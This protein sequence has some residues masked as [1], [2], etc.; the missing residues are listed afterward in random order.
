MKNIVYRVDGHH[1]AASQCTNQRMGREIEQ[2]DEVLYRRQKLSDRRGA[3]G[4]Q[5]WQQRADYVIA[6]EVATTNANPY[7]HRN[8]NLLQQ[9][10]DQLRFLWLQLDQIYCREQH[11]SS[12]KSGVYGIPCP[13]AFS[14]ILQELMSRTTRVDILLSR[15]R[16]LLVKTYPILLI[17]P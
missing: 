5:Y 12:T 1:R 2:L 14:T 4:Q 8:Y 7:C 16:I 6:A 3:P 17:I 10:P 15:L 9:S 11:N 13:R